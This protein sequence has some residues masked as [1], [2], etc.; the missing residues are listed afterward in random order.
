MLVSTH[1]THRARTTDTSATSWSNSQ[2]AQSSR[3]ATFLDTTWDVNNEAGGIVWSVLQPDPMHLYLCR[4]EVC[5]PMVRHWSA[6]QG[7]D[8]DDDELVTGS[9]TSSGKAVEKN[10]VG[11]LDLRREPKR[12]SHPTRPDITPYTS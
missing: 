9:D 10:E 4:D 7:L 5:S 1:C 8:D 6:T 11:G 3:S 2:L 12:T